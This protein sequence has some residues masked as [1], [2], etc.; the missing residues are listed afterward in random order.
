MALHLIQKLEQFT[1]LSLDDRRALE[2]AARERVRKLGAHEHITREGDNPR[3]VNLFLDGWACRYKSLQDG[4]RQIMAFFLPGDLCDMNIFVLREMDHSIETITPV[5]LAE[6]SRETLQYLTANY[7]RLSYALW[8]DTLV[9]AA[10][11]R[12]WSVNLGQRTAFERLGH[13]LCELFVRL[14]SVGL[15]VGNSCTL[16]L[17]QA[18]MADASGLSTVH[19]NRTL[20]E[21]RAA[22]LIILR[23]KELVIPDLAAL[24]DAALFNENYLHLN[25][26]GRHLDA[27]ES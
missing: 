13:L 7:P 3:Y 6:I 11:Q 4:R 14:R 17:T 21:L 23:G 24:R 27:N 8:W 26:D 5:T 1:R 15:T 16:P 9:E 10:I 12:E 18:E 25:H 2:Q 19:V 20:Q 22:G